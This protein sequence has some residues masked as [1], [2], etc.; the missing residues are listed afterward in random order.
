[1]SEKVAELQSSKSESLLII[2]KQQM[3]LE[4]SQASRIELET[5]LQSFTERLDA[6]KKKFTCQIGQL[7]ANNE[8]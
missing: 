6:E 7:K 2:E 5:L 8:N 4:K 1:M 3:D